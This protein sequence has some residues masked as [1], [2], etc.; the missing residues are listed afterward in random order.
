[1]SKMKIEN[2]SGDWK[3]SEDANRVH[4]LVADDEP[5]SLSMT[6]YFFRAKG[7]AV[8]TAATPNEIIEAVNG[9]L[10]KTGSHYDL[11]V[12][13]INFCGQDET[14]RKTGIGAVADIRLSNCRI[15]VVFVSGFLNE[16]VR[17]QTAAVHAAAALQKPVEV[18]E[19]FARSVAAI[20]ER[21]AASA[22]EIGEDT[23]FVETS[24]TVQSA[25]L[26]ARRG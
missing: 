16:Q 5:D 1:M 25:I 22:Y 12:T 7:W 23:E 4:I 18:E 9:K 19:L 11:I 3:S 13:D 21:R 14:P 8:D 26:A 10:E 15:P 20:N 6:A 24:G 17:E 2:Y